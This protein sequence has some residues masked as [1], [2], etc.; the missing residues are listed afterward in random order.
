MCTVDKVPEAITD[1]AAATAIM[2]LADPA[3][4]GNKVAGTTADD[5]IQVEDPVTP[6]AGPPLEQ[7]IV[8]A[9][10]APAGGD[11]AGAVAKR[12]SEQPGLNRR[13]RQK[14]DDMQGHQFIAQARAHLASDM[15]EKYQKILRRAARLSPT[16]RAA[17]LTALAGMIQEDQATS[18]QLLDQSITVT[19][20][21]ANK[22]SE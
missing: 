19:E 3:A 6:A 1:E 10:A 4:A 18:L 9:P 20:H 16:E 7:A 8:A 5:G 22:T 12:T 17:L 21:F 11:K 14:L 13:K 15:S 2:V